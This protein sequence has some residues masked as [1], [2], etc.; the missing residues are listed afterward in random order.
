MPEQ[1]LTDSVEFAENPMSRCPVVLLIDTS[2]S[3]S[4]DNRIQT[5]N[6]AM[7]EFIR[8]VKSDTQTSLSADIALVT[9]S[10]AVQTHEFTSADSFSPPMMTA[11]GG[12]KIALAVH[13]AL[14]M[15]ETRKAEYRD[16]GV[17]YYRPILM[18]ITDG[19]PEHDTPEEIEDARNRLMAEE[20]G[21]SVAFFA[22]G[23]EEADI[24]RI[25]QI[26]PPNRP[27]KSIGDVSQVN[28]IF[29]WLSNS[30]A[31]ISASN[32][33]ERLRLDPVDDYLDY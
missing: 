4:A 17:S 12:T 25:S 18:L 15:L 2:G 33:G 20:E 24:E 11:G 3:M 28:G 7:D 32:P 9:F 31:K 8:N 6:G 21:R 13:S 16:N 26:T 27:A 5:I 10:H 23:I 19:F 14:D 29:Q 30:I 22:F 1:N